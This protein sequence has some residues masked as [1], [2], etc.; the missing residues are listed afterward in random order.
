MLCASYQALMSVGGLQYYFNGIQTPNTFENRNFIRYNY[1]VR[2]FIGILSAL[3]RQK[4]KN[5]QPWPEKQY[6]Y[7]KGC[8]Y[9]S[10]FAQYLIISI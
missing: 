7:K 9:Y 1:N 6:S 3:N 4:N 10:V 8:S 2:I 5:I